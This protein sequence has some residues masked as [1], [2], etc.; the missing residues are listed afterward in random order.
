ME[1]IVTKEKTIVMIL[2]F[3]SS[4]VGLIVRTNDK[5]TIANTNGPITKQNMV[6]YLVIWLA[7]KY[8]KPK[9]PSIARNNKKK[10]IAIATIDKLNAV[11]S[12]LF[13][14]E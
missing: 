3:L 4:G 2:Y 14:L 12:L 13:I 5:A 7:N 10:N 11:L 1:P 6:A 9:R 8:D